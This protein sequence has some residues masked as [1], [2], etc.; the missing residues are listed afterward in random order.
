MA[1]NGKK[2]TERPNQMT[3]RWDLSTSA[4]GEHLYVT[5]RSNTVLA[6]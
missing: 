3:D 5:A 4:G 6:R 2:L 1:L